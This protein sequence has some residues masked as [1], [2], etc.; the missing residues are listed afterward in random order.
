MH[1]LELARH[2]R[3]LNVDRPLIHYRKGDMNIAH[4]RDRAADLR[5]LY[6]HVFERLG[7]PLSEEERELQLATV[8]C[9]PKPFTAADVVAFRWWL[10]RLAELGRSYG[11]F[12]PIAL[13]QQL[14]RHWEMLFYHLPAF[15]IGA[16]WQ[17]FRSGPAWDRRQWRYLLS[18]IL[19]GARS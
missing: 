19:S 15:G 16:T 3:F 8:K 14:D 18:Y 12:D 9:F 10:G 4:G 5:Y 1:Q 7:W 13:Q 11:T 2:T 17:H 6:T